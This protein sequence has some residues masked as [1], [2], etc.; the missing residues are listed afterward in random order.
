VTQIP[1]GHRPPALARLVDKLEAERFPRWLIPPIALCRVDANLRNFVRR[2]DGWVSVDWE[3]SGWGDPAFDLA[4]LRLH[5]AYLG[6]SDERWAWVIEKYLELRRKPA[7]RPRIA[8]YI[9]ILAI[10]WVTRIA[11]YLYELPRGLDTRISGQPTARVAGRPE[12]QAR[13][14][15]CT[16]RKVMGIKNDPSTVVACS[17]P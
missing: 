1:A 2:S 10:W 13:A 17:A 8:I 4:D 9:R 14:L 7:A 6:V 12:R 16:G 11:R 5:P 15:Y 3:N